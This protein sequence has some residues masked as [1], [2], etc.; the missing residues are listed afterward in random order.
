MF[1][2]YILLQWTKELRAQPADYV[3][4]DQYILLGQT[5]ANL[6]TEQAQ[7]GAKPTDNNGPV[8]G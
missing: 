4:P 3:G 1:V 6:Q 2:V 8:L 7:I 5:W